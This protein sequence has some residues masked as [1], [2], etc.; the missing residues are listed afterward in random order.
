M[1]EVYKDDAGRYIEGKYNQRYYEQSCERCG[2]A[3]FPRRRGAQKYCSQSCNVRACRERNGYET[4]D[5]VKVSKGKAA[6]LGQMEAIEKKL[7]ALGGKNMGFNTEML[8]STIA[9]NAIYDVGKAVA[10]SLFGPE[11]D[12]KEI[13]KRLAGIEARLANL[14]PSHPQPQLQTRT[15]PTM[16]PTGTRF[17]TPGPNGVLLYL[18]EFTDG[19]HT[20][21]QLDKT[22]ELPAKTP[23]KIN[24]MNF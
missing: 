8:K 10:K 11:D 17:R 14:Q 24:P 22:E 16:L 6:M 4:L 20:F 12:V 7:D 1:K 18:T 19:K 5:G 23:K 2:D 3:Y 21:F 15:G 9:G 13:K